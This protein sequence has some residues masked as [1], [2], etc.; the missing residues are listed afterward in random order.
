M[1][2]AEERMQADA[3]V[4]SPLTI[5]LLKVIILI[6]DTFVQSHMTCMSP[7]SRRIFLSQLPRHCCTHRAA[8]IMRTVGRH[9]ALLN[10]ELST[11]L[12]GAKRARTKANP[13]SLSTCSEN[14]LHSVVDA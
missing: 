14:S 5:Y 6:W 1:A 4:F 10:M 12:V 9:R 3:H 7:A 8:K 2:A 11:D 13:D